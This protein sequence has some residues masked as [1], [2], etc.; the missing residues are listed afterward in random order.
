[1]KTNQHP[2][3]NSPLSWSEPRCGVALV[4]DGRVGPTDAG[5]G[6][7]SRPPTSSNDNNPQAERAE[8]GGAD[9]ETE[10]DADDPYV[11]YRLFNGRSKVC[12]LLYCR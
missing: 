11:F 1:M 5:R 9:S 8:R 3:A 6:S 2:P 10:S 4:S 12:H 7:P